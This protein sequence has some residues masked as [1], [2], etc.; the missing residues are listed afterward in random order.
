MKVRPNVYTSW[1]R[2]VVSGLRFR[3]KMLWR[4]LVARY[5]RWIQ[6][7]SFAMVTVHRKKKEMNTVS[8]PL[9]NF[10]H[11]VEKLSVIFSLNNPIL[12]RDYNSYNLNGVIIASIWRENI[13][14]Y[15]FPNV[16]C[17]EMQTIFREW[18]LKKTIRVE[19]RKIFEHIF[20]L[21]GGYCVYYP[22]NFLNT[23]VKCLWTTYRLL[24]VA[25]F[26]FSVLWYDFINK[27][28]MS[29][30]CNNKNG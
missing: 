7:F 18:S 22:S 21:K 24:R 15:L 3:R 12:K 2:W 28:N 13:Y 17:S 23:V 4:E 20:G 19:E 1:K 16:I 6:R 14:G 30:L 11:K 10:L 5:R 8:N 29:L 26:I 25:W 9:K 27:Q